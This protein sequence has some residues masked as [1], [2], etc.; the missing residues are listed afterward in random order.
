[1]TFEGPEE[2][3]GA[4]MA[5]QSDERD[6]GSGAQE[7]V[8][9]VANEKVVTDLDFGGMG[10]A[11]ASLTLEPEADGTRVTWGLVTDMGNNPAMRWMG[12]A[13][14]RMV[15]KDY[16]SGLENLKTLVEGS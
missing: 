12:L 6:V 3:V 2:G 10:T 16:E 7:I 9:S 11:A 1:M 8:E 13:M 14:D 5:W 4:K 15:G